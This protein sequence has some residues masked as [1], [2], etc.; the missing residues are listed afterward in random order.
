MRDISYCNRHDCTRRKTCERYIGN[1]STKDLVTF[2]LIEDPTECEHYYPKYIADFVGC[3]HE[4]C[5]RKC[6]RK[7]V[8]DYYINTSNWTKKDID[9]CEYY[10]GK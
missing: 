2:I 6:L 10:R 3:D 1:T 9:T 8:S 5:E 7:K 4:D